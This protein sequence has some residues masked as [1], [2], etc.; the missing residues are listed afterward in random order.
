MYSVD[1]IRTPRDRVSDE[2]I[3][4]LV[5]QEGQSMNSARAC[6]ACEEAEARGSLYNA[7]MTQRNMQGYGCR[8]KE[9]T[10]TDTDS[11]CEGIARCRM[12]EGQ[13]LAMVYSPCNVW[14]GIYAP[15]MALRRGTMFQE[16]DKPW[17]VEKSRGGCNCGK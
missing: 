15:D 4:R 8:N 5:E 3:R 10:C 12:L 11:A 6:R 7:S 16:L 9:T 14:R 17:C 2:F 1:D 13:P